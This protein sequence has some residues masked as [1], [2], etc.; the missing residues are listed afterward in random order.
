MT[1]V[2]SPDFSTFDLTP[3]GA[4]VFSAGSPVATGTAGNPTAPSVGGVGRFFWA[5]YTPFYSSDN[6]ASGGVISRTWLA[7][8]GGLPP[9]SFSGQPS[10][11]ATAAMG[12]IPPQ[13][14]VVDK[15]GRN[16]DG[17]LNGAPSGGYRVNWYNPT[18]DAQNNPVPPD[19][20]VVEFKSNGQAVHFMLPGSFPSGTQAVNNLLLTDART[21]LPSGHGPTPAS[22]IDTPST[23]RVA[24]DQIAPG[25]CR[26][27]VP[28]EL[29]PAAGS[30]GQLTIFAVK[31]INRN[32]P[33]GGARPLNRPDWIDAIKT[34]TATIQILVG[35]GVDLG[36]AHKIPFNFPWDI[37]V[38]NGPAISVAS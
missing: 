10:G 26:F 9:T 17:S 13:G 14:T 28:L 5:A 30:T 16:A 4:G 38:V 25:Y 3:S 1:G 32:H 19:F 21:F 35:G 34:A 6:S 29:R 31:T 7:D 15:H 36:Y 8:A 11:D 20:W 2:I 24:G 18:V 37:V 22:G 23:G 33:V 27:D 12:F